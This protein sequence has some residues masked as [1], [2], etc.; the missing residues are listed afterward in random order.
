MDKRYIILGLIYGVIFFDTLATILFLRL[1]LKEETQSLA[2]VVPIHLPASEIKEKY[3]SMKENNPKLAGQ[4]MYQ[5][6]LPLHG[7]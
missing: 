6:Q 7:K 4:L 5:E 2:P 3:E 1:R